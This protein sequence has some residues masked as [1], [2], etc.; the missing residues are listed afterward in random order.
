MHGRLAVLASCFLAP[1][2]LCAGAVA[3]GAAQPGGDAHACLAQSNGYLNAR[4]GYWQQRLN[5]A[6]WKLSLVMS[7]TSELKPKTLGNIHWDAPKKTAVIRVLF[8]SDYKVPC[9]EALPDMEMTLV[10]ELVHLELSSLPR[11]PASRHD[12]ELAVN[13]IADALVRLDR[14]K[15]VAPAVTANTGS[16]VTLD[17][18]PDAARTRTSTPAPTR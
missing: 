15:V 3:T 7:H 4:L 2:L 12:E 1:W 5:L 16:S 13:R 11:S 8:A 18:K 6:D 10:H 17:G 14:Q 9:R